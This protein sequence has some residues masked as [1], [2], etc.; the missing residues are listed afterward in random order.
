VTDLTNGF[1]L[2]AGFGIAYRG[3]I[4]LVVNPAKR[5]WPTGTGSRYALIEGLED[6]AF[7]PF[8]TGPGD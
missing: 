7:A 2:R 6:N 4:C 3:R 1:F 5:F 8:L